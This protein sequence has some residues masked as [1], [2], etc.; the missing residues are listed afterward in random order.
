MAVRAHRANRKL[1]S[2]SAL[3]PCAPAARVPQGTAE[4]NGGVL[5]SLRDWSLHRAIPST[6]RA[7]FQPAAPGILPG[8][9]D[10]VRTILC[11]SA[12]RDVRAFRV[13]YPERRVKYPPY[14]RLHCF[15]ALPGSQDCGSLRA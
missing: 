10:V 1:P 4:I 9:S 14:P 2:A 6:G 5:P 13:G 15:L 11:K 8:A 12:H 7:G 3:G